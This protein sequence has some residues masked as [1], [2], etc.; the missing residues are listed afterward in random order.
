[1][2]I[3]QLRAQ[4]A[5]LQDAA[6]DENKNFHSS[7][8]EGKFDALSVV[9]TLLDS[10]QEEPVSKDLEEA[11]VEAFKQIVD[12]DKNSFLEIFKA[13]AKWKEE[14]YKKNLLDV[15]KKQTEEEAEIERDFIEG[16]IDEHR[17]PT[18][19]DAIK[20]GMRLQK[21]QIMKDAIDA[22]LDDVCGFLTISIPYHNGIAGDKVKVVIIKSE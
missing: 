10:L 6:M 14:L 1:M 15:C 16:I 12:L 3:Q 7:Y 21:E 13:G 19:D 11:A 4:I 9:D 8:D 18:F 20:Y 17:L 5:A 22:E 2:N